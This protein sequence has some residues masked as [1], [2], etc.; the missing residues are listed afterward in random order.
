VIQA[1]FWLSV[2][3]AA[4]GALTRNRTAW[5]LL[6][7]VAFCLGLDAAEVKFHF[8]FWM[9]ID[10]VVVLAIIHPKMTRTD[11]VILALFIPAWC[12]YLMPDEA[13]FWGTFVVVVAQLTLTFPVE[14]LR[15]LLTGLHS[16]FRAGRFDEMVC[17]A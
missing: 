2:A 15:R 6:A 17:H 16:R 4:C 3:C 1:V 11:C 12:F 9:L 14:A 13:R 7:S 10:T 5:V 8:V